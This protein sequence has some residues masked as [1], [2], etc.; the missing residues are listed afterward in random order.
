MDIV[1][2]DLPEEYDIVV[3]AHKAFLCPYNSEKLD[4]RSQECVFLCY[5]TSLSLLLPHKHNSSKTPHLHQVTLHLQPPLL[6]I[7]KPNILAPTTSSSPNYCLTLAVAT[8]NSGPSNLKQNPTPV[9][10]PRRIHNAHLTHTKAKYGIRLTHVVY[11][12]PSTW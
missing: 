9:Q 7:L 2:E 6:K 3:T 10:L 11:C 5:S 8:S 1:L 12:F 4:Y